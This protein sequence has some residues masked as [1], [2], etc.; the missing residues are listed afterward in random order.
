MRL[1]GALIVLISTVLCAQNEMNEGI[2]AFKS[3]NY[4]QAIEL[5]TQAAALHPDEVNPHLYLGT[6]YMS[7][8]PVEARAAETE[9]K[10]V[11]ELDANNTVAM[12]SLASLAL[13]RAGCCR[14]RSRVASWMK[15][16]IGT[17]GW[18]RS[19]RRIKRLTIRWE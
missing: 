5:F 14:A 8:S 10:R 3:G 13:T 9:F 12:A 2:A 11:L 7:A 18:W 16:G 17:N 19:S 15:L 1:H 4:K 6:A